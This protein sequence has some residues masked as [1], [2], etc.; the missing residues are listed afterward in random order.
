M[1]VVTPSRS[2]ELLD[3]VSA[4]LGTPRSL[5]DVVAGIEN[6]DRLRPGHPAAAQAR[7]ANLLVTS[8]GLGP[9]VTTMPHPGL[10]DTPLLAAVTGVDETADSVVPVTVAFTNSADE[11]AEGDASPESALTFTTGTAQ[12]LRTVSHHIPVTRQ[13]LAHNPTLRADIDTYLSGGVLVKLEQLL[14]DALADTLGV[15]MHAFDTNIAT[16]VRTAIAKAQSAM[17]ELGPGTVTVVLSPQDHAK[18]DLA[19]GAGLA[20]WPASIASTPALPNGFA[21][22]SR[23][24]QAAQLFAS[25]VNIAVGYIGTQFPQNKVTVRADVEALPHLAAP[26]AVIKA[27]LS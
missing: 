15:Q 10:V 24:K 18:L 21:Y 5:G 11:T 19:V 14:A 2:A 1:T 6:L 17:R 7:I 3:L 23:F 16:T 4:E 20:H 8:G 27:A 13:A 22:V 25:R 12:V 26:A 9:E